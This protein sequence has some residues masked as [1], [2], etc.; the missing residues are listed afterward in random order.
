MSRD[1]SLIS[2]DH[3]FRWI[4]AE[5]AQAALFGVPR[6][7]LFTPK[8][9]DPFRMTRYG[10]EM[11]TPLGVASGPH[12]QMAQNI[13]IAWMCGSRYIELKTVQTLDEL[14][15]SKPCIDMSDEGYNCEWS[16]ELRLKD[17][18]NEYLN[19]W[20]IL[21]ALR[22]GLGHNLGRPDNFG[23]LF[24][25]SVGY[26]M[27]GL[28]KPNV[29]EFFASMRDCRKAKE[30]KMSAMAKLY[31]EISKIE[32]P[33]R[34]SDNITLSTM[35]GCP[36]EEIEKIGRYLI[37]EL[38]LNTTIKLN[39]TLLGPTELRHI[40]NEK[41]RFET[42]VPDE[43]FGHDLKYP[44]AIALIKSLRAAAAKNGVH[45]SL[46]LTNTLESVNHKN[47]F[48]PNEKMMYMSG[49]A[50]HPISVRVAHKLQNEFNGELDISFSA[51]ADAF[52]L[53]ELLA[54]GIKP[55]TVC[56]DVLK[57]GGYGRLAQYLDETRK[58]MR[59]TGAK[60]I[61]EFIVKTADG[62]VA[63]ISPAFVRRCALANLSGYSKVVV[64]NPLYARP[65][66]KG[67]SVKTPR[68]L[69]YF[70]C[71]SAPCV[72]TCAAHQDI[73][74][75]MYH[76]AHGEDEK[77]MDVILRTNPLPNICG[78]VCDHL[79]QSRCTRI[80]YD[81]PLLIREIKRFVTERCQGRK[82]E[83]PAQ[84]G[85]NVAVIGAGP[86]G[87]ACAYF[88]I[89]EGF[90]VEVFE[91]K[92]FAGGMASDAIPAFRLKA[93]A[94]CSDIRFIESLGVKLHF[95]AHINK[96]A[97]AN[98]RNEFIYVYLAVGAQKAKLMGIP[99]ENS[100][101]CLDFLTFLA[102]VRRGKA[103]DL[104]KH[105][106]VL[107]GGNSAMDV[108]RTANRLHGNGGN[109][110]V[111]YR[112]TR[113]E[114]PADREEIEALIH[115]GIKILELTA[116]VEILLE[117]GKV[118]ALRCSK[119]RLGEKDSSGRA[120]PVRIEGADFDLPV[121]TIIPAIGQDVQIDFL[122]DANL[123]TDP[124]T[125]QT[126]MKNVY[127]GGDLTR[128]ASFVIK[129]IGD[130]KNA[131]MNIIKS[132]AKWHSDVATRHSKGISRTEHRKR[133]AFRQAG[134]VIPEIGLE[135]RH[136][137]DLVNLPLD[138][139]TARAEASR[140]LYC[141]DACG[142]CVTVCPNRA[143]VNYEVAIG[144]YPIIRALRANETSTAARLE[145][146]GTLRVEQTSQILNIGDF[147]NECGNCTTFCP[148]SGSPYKD[149]P[150]FYLTEKSFTHEENAY[151]LDG[152][153]LKARVGSKIE[154]LTRKSD[155]TFVYETEAVKAVLDGK[156]LTV[157]E[158]SFAAS[159][160]FSAVDLRHAVTMGLML[161]G[162]EK[163]VFK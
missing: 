124:V 59:T 8:V 160:A 129:A 64:D 159:G 54:C 45:F 47:V 95:N 74:E 111:I 88:L 112:R 141:D 15:V 43:A 70:D 150:K 14:N 52:N 86:S 46:K 96:A 91:T 53:H 118:K 103:F 35:H 20:I 39:P 163:A 30:E 67:A 65:Y 6:D 115:E 72:S 9:D 109:V 66:R 1:F 117:D 137:F 98:I 122:D 84:N 147:C 38:K 89:K 71:I 41:L 94:I 105:V 143:N 108:A 138:E 51:G 87:L 154:T 7:L 140:C 49:R 120:K 27:E 145:P 155:G 135:K 21:H 162:L 48:P 73:P 104:G 127:A 57:P 121:D 29:Q 44:D 60:T 61:D 132:A 34:I 50:L 75:Y 92:A 102:D 93:E 110:T 5:E 69:D 42:H 161:K 114:M 152:D 106:A 18:F 33:D 56:S 113:A 63:D 55:V 23:G 144:D 151:R 79:C 107:G 83:I 123:G 78:L 126:R 26:N 134:T 3:L 149:K 58:A 19:A 128:G 131:A 148:T 130:G 90:D 153:K 97:F 28:L 11:E 142:I 37:E 139:K 24:N 16:Q 82:P 81:Q 12:T 36:P 85:L 125:G 76:V 80:N 17:S 146:I 77:A 4:L 32:I 157:R 119:M 22:H 10:R 2:I 13:I 116:P 136:G 101:G 68:P 158:A 31:P 133:R 40:L 100:E 99:G 156:T 62:D 25:M